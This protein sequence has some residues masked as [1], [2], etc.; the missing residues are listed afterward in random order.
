M[1][2]LYN[3]GLADVRCSDNVIF[4][5]HHMMLVICEALCNTAKIDDVFVCKEEV[6]KKLLV[7][8][9]MALFFVTSRP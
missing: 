2:K 7:Q 9:P 5:T 6:N 8:I 1:T 4:I 3:C